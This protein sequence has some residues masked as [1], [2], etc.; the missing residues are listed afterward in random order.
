LKQIEKAVFQTIFE[1]TVDAPAFEKAISESLPD[2]KLINSLQNKI[3]A[4]EKELKR[5]DK[6]LDKLV[7]LALSGTLKKET[8][9]KK[10]KSLLEAKIITS[11]ELEANRDKLRSLPDIHQVKQ[12]AEKIRPQLL[13]RFSGKG[14][15][16]K[17][18]FDEKK[19]LLH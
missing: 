13:E 11:E 7:E 4:G 5:I 1:N 3:Q 2:E 14:R 6:E 19:T 16:K 18:T 12:E 17:M 15:L 10:E 9:R 8:I